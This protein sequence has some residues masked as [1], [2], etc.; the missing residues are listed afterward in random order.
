MILFKAFAHAVIAT[1]ILPTSD[2]YDYRKKKGACGCH[3]G[4]RVHTAPSV[5]QRCKK[6]SDRP[7]TD[8]LVERSCHSAWAW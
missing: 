5:A 1:S 6:Q 8:P 2:I 4:S 7:G 3:N